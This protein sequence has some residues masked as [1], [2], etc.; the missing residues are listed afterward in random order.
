M[1]M[2]HRAHIR[3]DLVPRARHEAKALGELYERH[4]AGVFRYCLHRLFVRE[5]G[6]DVTSEVFLAVA[7]GIRQFPG[8][9]E[10]DFR[11]WLYAI[12]GNQVSAYLR[13]RSRRKALLEAAARQR[14]IA[15]NDPP[16]PTDEL[17]WPILYQAIA[18]L[19]QREQAVVTLRCLEK[20]PFQDIA[21]TL[22]IRPVTARVSFHRA[23][24]QLRARLA[25]PFGRA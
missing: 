21:A 24:K 19:P 8:R 16:D 2:P 20:W 12:A 15:L 11:N 9:T 1:A 23:L 5:V 4:Y 14:R 17:D 6:E 7:R 25:R 10:A 3:N 13:T 22:A 18:D